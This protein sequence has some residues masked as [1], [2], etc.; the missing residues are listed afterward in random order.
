MLRIESLR[1]EVYLA[2]ISRASDIGI[3]P[4]KFDN[5]NMVMNE[6]LELTF[7]RCQNYWVYLIMQSFQLNL[8]W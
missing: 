6:I 2:Y 1:E 7:W 5:R 3:T 4:K 8:R